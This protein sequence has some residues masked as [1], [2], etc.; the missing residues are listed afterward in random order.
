MQNLRL[1]PRLI[2]IA[3]ATLNFCTIH[4]KVLYEGISSKSFS[5]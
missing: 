1:L 2:T 3:Y 5:I 4:S